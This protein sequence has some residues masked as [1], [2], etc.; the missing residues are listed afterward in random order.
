MEF[1]DPQSLDGFS[2]ETD[3]TSSLIEQPPTLQS[4]TS[5]KE[6]N[7]CNIDFYDVCLPTLGYGCGVCIAILTSPITI[8]LL[9]LGSPVMLAIWIHSKCKKRNARPVLPQ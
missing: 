2:N 6:Y 3:D 9:I 4:V 5:L 8:P 1:S 7:E